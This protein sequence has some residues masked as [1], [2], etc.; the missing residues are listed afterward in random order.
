MKD[1]NLVNLRTRLKKAKDE[2]KPL[3]SAHFD[4]K[5][6]YS[7]IQNATSLQQIRGY[8]NKIARSGIELPSSWTQ[9]MHEI[10]TV[11]NVSGA[12]KASMTGSMQPNNSVSRIFN[13]KTFHLIIKP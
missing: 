6:L 13:L 2:L 3:I 7:N 11:N 12:R 5:F 8:I 10:S 9:L 1:P 4:R